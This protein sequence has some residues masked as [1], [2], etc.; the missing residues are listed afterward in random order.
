MVRRVRRFSAISGVDTAL[1]AATETVVVT[2]SGIIGEFS[3]GHV[4][5]LGSVALTGA[6]GV[7]SVTLRVRRGSVAGALVA[8]VVVVQVP[9][10]VSAVG[11]IQVEEDFVG[12]A[13]P[14]YVLTATSTGGAS[15]ATLEDLVA[16]V[17]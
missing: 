9:G 3:D 6:A 12:G 1:P 14:V 11:A 15:T 8:E 13:F 7:T 2:V 17:T 5:L 4:V 16:L 10:A